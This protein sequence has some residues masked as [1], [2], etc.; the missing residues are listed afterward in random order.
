MSPDGVCREFAQ[1]LKDYR[2]HAIVGDNYGNEWPRERFSAHGIR[3]EK[4]DKPKAGL[5]QELLP[6][7]NSGRIELP[8]LPRLITQI[9][10][11]ERRASSMGRDIIDHPKG[12]SYH[13]DLANA[14]AGAASLAM[15]KGSLNFTEADVAAV[16][17]PPSP[18]MSRFGRPSR[19]DRGRRMAPPMT[20]QGSVS[21]FNQPVQPMSAAPSAAFGSISYSDSIEK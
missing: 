2:I 4:C 6:L 20:F 13:D 21:G 10:Q 19:F 1:L 14:I 7:L 17:R 9:C 11:L 8:D 15:G 3:Y 16:S 12:A 18:A 5:Y